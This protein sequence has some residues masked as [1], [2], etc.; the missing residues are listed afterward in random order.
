M[1]KSGELWEYVAV[2]IDSLAFVFYVTQKFI[3]QLTEKYKYKLKGT[4][5]IFFHIGCN[6]FRDEDGTLCMT[7][8]QYIEK[9]I[10]GYTNIFNTNTPSIIKSPLE[11]GDHPELGNSDI[12]DMTG[13]HQYQSLIGSI[14]W[15]VSIEMLVVST[16]VMSLS[17]Y[18]SV[19]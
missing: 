17:G 10:Y 12:L 6:V 14:Q 4:C 3:N 15:A 19:P 1:R 9:V 11:K 16:T 13:I 2:Y 5:S 8:K 18:R 7:P